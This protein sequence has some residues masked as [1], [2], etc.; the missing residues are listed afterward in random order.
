MKILLAGY[1][2]GYMRVL[3][4]KLAEAGFETTEAY[5]LAEAQSHIG[6]LK[7]DTVI[8]CFPWLKGV[9]YMTVVSAFKEAWRGADLI[10][11]D[12]H[13]ELHVAVD[14]IHAGV[15]SCLNYPFATEQLLSALQHA[16]SRFGHPT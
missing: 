16:G 12:R 2:Q 6:N 7:P 11:I 5:S 15:F 4:S 1:P 10:I 9:G 8:C 14:L 3:G 13:I